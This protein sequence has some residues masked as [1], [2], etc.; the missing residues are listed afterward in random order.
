MASPWGYAIGGLGQGLAQGLAL[1]GDMED[2][3]LRREQMKRQEETA[4][5]KGAIDLLIA[6]SKLSDEHPELMQQ[7]VGYASKQLGMPLNMAT[8]VP[9]IERFKTANKEALAAGM[10]PEQANSWAF[11][12]VGLTAPKGGASDKQNWVAVPDPSKPGGIGFVQGPGGN[13]KMPSMG[14]QP[15]P[16][17]DPAKPTA[18]PIYG[19]PGAKALPQQPAWQV[20]QT[21]ETESGLTAGD[22]KPYDALQAKYNA[23]TDP[24]ERAAIEK[25]IT[26]AGGTIEKIPQPKGFFGGEYPDKVIVIPPA[27]KKRTSTK[28]PG[29][30]GVPEPAQNK[31]IAQMTLEELKALRDSLAK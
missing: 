24:V 6:G 29:L 31:P 14:M 1:G 28:T 7:F 10:S 4:T 25:R 3:K 30:G 13:L 5:R 22:L 23:T 21:T 2:R 18:P 20:P 8:A 17:I 11:Q 16:F 19:P 26:E 9:A 27:T 15:V 12:K